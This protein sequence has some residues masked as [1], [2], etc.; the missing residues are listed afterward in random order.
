MNSEVEIHLL[1]LSSVNPH[2]AVVRKE[3]FLKICRRP[4]FEDRIFLQNVGFVSEQD[5]NG[6]RKYST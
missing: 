5:R 3:K 2:S 6:E 4:N 1:A